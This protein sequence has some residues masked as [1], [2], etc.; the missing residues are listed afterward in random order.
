MSQFR[1]A[2]EPAEGRPGAQ[3]RE[4]VENVRGRP[5]MPGGREAGSGGGFET[6]G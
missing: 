1:T 2:G 5:G 4:L 6:W 3:A